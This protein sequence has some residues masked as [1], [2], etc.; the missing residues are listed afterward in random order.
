MARRARR[1]KN[2]EAVMRALSRAITGLELPAIEK[3]SEGQQENPFQVLIAT[4]RGDA[5]IGSLS[6]NL[7]RLA[8]AL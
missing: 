6:R 3:I 7:H 8:H 5:P 4:L 1:P 2:V